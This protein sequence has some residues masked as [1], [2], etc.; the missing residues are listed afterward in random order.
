MDN[1]DFMDLYKQFEPMIIKIVKQWSKLNIVEYDDLMQ[2]ALIALMEARNSYDPTKGMKFSTYIY[3]MIEYKMKREIYQASKKNEKYRTVSIYSTVENAEGD[4]IEL[5]ELLADKLDLEDE[6]RNKLMID[7]YESE[8][9]RILPED[10]FNVCYLRW[11]K[12]LPYET[13]EKA[14]RVKNVSGILIDSRIKLLQ[15]SLVLKEEYKKMN[16]LNDY[17][18][19]EKL[20]LI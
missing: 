5:I 10:K 19:T 3:N 18:D 20:A 16:N 11:F 6:V 14:L 13:I 15:R 4:T 1:E 8:C 2:F 12:G 9:K 7:Y 17:S